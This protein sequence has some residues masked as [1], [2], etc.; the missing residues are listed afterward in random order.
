MK[1]M[2]LTSPMIA[3]I[4]IAVL[5]CLGQAY[6]D[7]EW[8]G[9]KGDLGRLK[10]AS[11]AE[12]AQLAALQASVGS[13]KETVKGYDAAIGPHGT[14]QILAA[15]LASGDAELS[16]RSLKVVS[17]GKPVVSIGS[18]ADAGGVLTVAAH[19]GTGSA[20]ISLSLIHIS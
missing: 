13:F 8:L 15:G 10:A 7:I 9:A 18:A 2:K 16:V 19:D 6:L 14:I 17:N 4:S 20:E 12:A 5:L 1:C 3:A 11:A